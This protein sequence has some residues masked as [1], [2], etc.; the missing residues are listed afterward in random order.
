MKASLPIF[1]ITAVAG[2]WLGL[3]LLV[4]RAIGIHV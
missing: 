1:V 4:L 2:V 3:V